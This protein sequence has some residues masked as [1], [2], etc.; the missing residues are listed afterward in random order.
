[1]KRADRVVN[2]EIVPA[3]PDPGQMARAAYSP[4]LLDAFKKI[5]RDYGGRDRLVAR[6]AFAPFDDRLETVLG[7]IAEAR[8][9]E[10]LADT[11]AR[12]NIR[13]AELL[14]YLK[15]ANQ[16]YAQARA[17]RHL[18]EHLDRTV[19]DTMTAAH[20]HEATCDH[21]LGAT[22]ITLPAN[23]DAGRDQPEQIPCP[24][25]QGHGVRAYP[26]DPEARKL[27]LDLGGLLQKKGGMNLAVGV[28]SVIQQ[29]PGGG[30]LERL[31]AAIAAT[32]DDDG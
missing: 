20:V 27:A 14:T 28:Q 17:S 8:D 24:L 21:C 6:L 25:C 31:Q 19:E 11:C 10:L 7:I 23:P 15:A 18:P 26:P 16:H 4:A 29:G 32:L 13:P 9:D 2:G 22:T 1:M 30:R 5:E 3:G 12:G